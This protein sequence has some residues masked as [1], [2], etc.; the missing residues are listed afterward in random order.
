MSDDVMPSLQTLR[1][2]FLQRRHTTLLVAIVIL[3]AVRPLIGEGQTGPVLFSVALIVLM[4]VALYTVQIDELAGEREVLLRRKRRHNMLGWVLAALAA[5]ERVAVLSS[6][7]RQTSLVGSV[8]WLLFFGFVTWSQFRSLLKQKEITSESISLSISVYLLLALSW[9]LLYIVIFEYQP[10]AF[11]LGG[12]SPTSGGQ[13]TFA[14]LIYF[15]LTTLSTIG[16]GDITPLT[17]QS[18]YAAV[19]EGITGQFYLAI[20]V[21][22]LVGMQMSQSASNRA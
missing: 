13:S 4:L 11:S 18:R 2:R 6:P 9:G 14:V 5:V 12:S 21:A 1:S 16:F 3:F 20:L 8:C 19:A 7:T 22:R 15:S 10:E 17:L